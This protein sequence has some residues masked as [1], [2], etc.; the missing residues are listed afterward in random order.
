[1]PPATQPHQKARRLPS[2]HLR[3]LNLDHWSAM[4]SIPPQIMAPPMATTEIN[5]ER[6]GWFRMAV[7]SRNRTLRR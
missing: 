6:A 5:A 2:D 7:D 3:S 1:M 4:N